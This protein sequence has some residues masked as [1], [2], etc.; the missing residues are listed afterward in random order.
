MILTHEDYLNLVKTLNAHSA[1]YYTHDQPKISD[2]E[3]D[4]LYQKLLK[5]IPTRLF[6]IYAQRGVQS[7]T[8]TRR[9]F[10]DELV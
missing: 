4:R 2:Q 5:L 7:T 9:Y 6:A 8:C 3:Y 1:H 10:T